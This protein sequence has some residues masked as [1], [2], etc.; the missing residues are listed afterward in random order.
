MIVNALLEEPRDWFEVDVRSSLGLGVG[1]SCSCQRGPQGNMEAR[2]WALGP[3]KDE[4][5]EEAGADDRELN[6]VKEASAARASRIVYQYL[7]DGEAQRPELLRVRAGG[8][9]LT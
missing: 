2:G 1:L 7:A 8:P 3:D 5:E 6:Y 4:R 9:Q